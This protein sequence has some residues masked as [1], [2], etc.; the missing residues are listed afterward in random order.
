VIVLGG[1]GG[2]AGVRSQVQPQV[3]EED[4][5]ALGR[6]RASGRRADA[7]VGAGHQC[8]PAVQPR[9]DHGVILPAWVNE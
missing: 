6:E 1:I 8:H 5:H 2:L 7:V 9:V 3:G 4:R